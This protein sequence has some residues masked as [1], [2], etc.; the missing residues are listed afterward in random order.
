M[1]ATPSATHSGPAWVAALPSGNQVAWYNSNA[2]NY[3][4]IVGALTLDLFVNADGMAIDFVAATSFSGSGG[5]IG[6]IVWGSGA[7]VYLD[8]EI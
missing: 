5:D 1:R 2:A 4:T 8:A 7:S 6:V 3:A